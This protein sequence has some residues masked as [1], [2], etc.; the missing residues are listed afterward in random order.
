MT[1]LRT[2]TVLLTALVCGAGSARAQLG[3]VQLGGIINYGVPDAF[4]TGA[5]VVAGIAAGRLAYIGVHWSYQRGSTESRDLELERLEITNR[6][7]VFAVD[8][9]LLIPVGKLELVPGASVGVMRLAQRIDGP[10]AQS[11][12]VHGEEFFVA[13]GFALHVPAV[14]L[15]LIPEAQLYLGGRPNLPR[16]ASARGLVTALRIVIPIEVGRVRW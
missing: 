7:Q 14:G 13:P 12:R 6:V 4:G 3:E 16:P 5:G 10:L 11:S 2:A 9:G 1:L 15:V 8:L